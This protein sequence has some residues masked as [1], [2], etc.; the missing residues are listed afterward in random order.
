LPY[1]PLFISSFNN[2]YKN[3]RMTELYPTIRTV[4]NSFRMLV[5]ASFAFAFNSAQGQ[6]YYATLNGASEAPPN[7]S[8]GTGK[9]LVT[10]SGNMMRVQVSF[11]GLTGNTTA[12]HIHAPTA[13][14]GAGTAGVATTTPTFTG[15]P[16]GVTAGTYDHTYD[17]T[18][19]TSYNPSYITANG[20]TAA[21]AFT[22]LKAS[23]A[24]GKSYLNIH[25]NVVPGGEIRGFLVA[26]PN[27]MVSIPDVYA[28]PKGVVANTVYPGYAPASSVGLQANVTGGTAPYTYSWSN[29]VTTA[30]NW[31]S[32]T[33]T[34]MYTAMVTDQN[35]C[36]GSATK[37]VMVVNVAG[38]Q[39]GKQVM[40]CH[41]G[42]TIAVAAP[43]IPAHLDHGD[44]LGACEAAGQTGTHRDMDAGQ[45]AGGLQV[46]VLA[47]PSPNYFDIQLNSTVAGYM[48]LK[49]YDLQGRLLETKPSLRGN[50]TLRLGASYQPGVYLVQIAVGNEMRTIRLIKTH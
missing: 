34:T 44:M 9:A 26:C 25:T 10:I 47:N 1:L 45:L 40:V 16:L 5:F 6:T 7:S 37:T 24:A 23:I 13:T 20:G 11:S 49:V 14:A 50:E 30:S 42:Q 2:Y 48:Q 46:K 31:V 29:G 28:L 39:N 17:M 27:V 41:K 8:A 33:M 19:A 38:G 32:P 18:V 43:A 22:A 36:S 12:S 4:K 15:F 35:G 21:S 3:T